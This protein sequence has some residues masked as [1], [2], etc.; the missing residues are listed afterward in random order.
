M[1]SHRLRLTNAAQADAEVLAW[2]EQA[3]SER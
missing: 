2:L 1:V 3:Y